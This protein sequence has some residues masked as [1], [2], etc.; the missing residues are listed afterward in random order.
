M[1]KLILTA[2]VLMVFGISLVGC[3]AE[4]QVD[5]PNSAS[6]VQLAQ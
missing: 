4:G 5:K 2:L 6:S 3:K 1:T